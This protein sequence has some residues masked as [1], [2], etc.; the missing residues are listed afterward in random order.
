[1]SGD[2]NHPPVK[3]ILEHGYAL[4][5][6]NYRLTT[7]ECFPVQIHDCKAAIRFLRAHAAEYKLDPERIGVWGVSAGGHLASLLGTS[8]D[9]KELE[10]SLGN[11]EV[12]S[13]VQAVADWAGP[14]DL[15]SIASQA[16]KHSKIDF[17]SPSNPVAVLLGADHQ[18]PADYLAASPI[19]Y[20]SADDPPFFIAHAEDD[21][22]VPVGQSKELESALIK[23]HV[24]VQVRIT[25][26]GG[27]S[28]SKP[29]FVF[30]TMNFFDKHLAKKTSH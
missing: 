23:E 8:G 1:M 18:E 10:G 4:A 22:V 25:H 17:K 2:K 16:P 15:V 6:L 26:N 14:S 21:D 12:S 24:P 28:L 20:V 27:H 9:V 7:H 29:E 13:R 30:E 19:H 5:S 11:N 3:V